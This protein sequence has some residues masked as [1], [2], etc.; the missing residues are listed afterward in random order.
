[1]KRKDL[2]FLSMRISVIRASNNKVPSVCSPHSRYLHCPMADNYRSCT[3][4]G[5]CFKGMSNRKQIFVQKDIVDIP[6]KTSE[7]GT[8]MLSPEERLSLIC[9]VHLHDTEH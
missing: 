3:C 9:T 8:A 4:H 7:Q 2:I 1:M 5:M 6:G